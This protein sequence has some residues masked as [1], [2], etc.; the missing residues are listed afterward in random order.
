MTD[1]PSTLSVSRALP[2]LWG[3]TRSDRERYLRAVLREHPEGAVLATPIGQYLVTASPSAIKHVLVTDHHRYRKGLGQAQARQ[4]IGEGLLTAEGETW[5]RQ[6]KDA[7]IHLRARSV[8]QHAA[9]F[10]EAARRSVDEFGTT[11]GEQDPAAHLAGYTLTCLSRTLDITAP[12]PHAVHAAFNTVQ[13]EALFRSVTQGVLPLSV[14]TG[15]RDRVHR[16]LDDL[17]YES[18][19]ALRGQNRRESWATPEGMASLFLAGYETTA[20]TLAWAVI[21]L[22]ARPQLQSA[23]RTEAYTALSTGLTSPGD[24]RLVEAFLKEVLRVRP[25]VWMISREATTADVVDGVDLRPGDQVLILP[26]VAAQSGWEDP[27]DF[28]PQRFLTGHS[29]STPWFGA[30]IRACPGSA[31][32]HLEGVLWLAH[33]CERWRLRL[34]PGIPLGALARMSQ[35]PNSDLRELID[36]TEVSRP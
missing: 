25:P 6:R 10:E 14:R 12:E 4:I 19:A 20:S 30:G 16:A 13:N 8:E 34:R 1:S 29:G 11:W 21:N 15:T 9:F 24:L 32:A 35:T 33:L 26:A 23:L 36:V 17:A 5:Q 28:R 22:A 2:V 27:Q 7:A 18:A 3:L 31:L